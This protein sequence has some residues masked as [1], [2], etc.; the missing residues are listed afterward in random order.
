M[1][2]FS[3]LFLLTVHFQFSS[4]TV[5]FLT[6]ILSVTISLEQFLLFTCYLTFRAQ[7]Q[8]VYV[9]ILV[10]LTLRGSSC[11]RSAYLS[12]F[13]VLLPL[14][15]SLSFSSHLVQL[16]S[17]IRTPFSLSPHVCFFGRTQHFSFLHSFLLLHVLLLDSRAL[18]RD[19][20]CYYVTPL[21]SQLISWIQLI[22]RLSCLLFRSFISSLSFFLL[23]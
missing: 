4:H 6:A 15:L 23:G 14:L 7:S 12:Y 19:I 1:S 11:L 21:S 8:R 18:L 16:H 5:A 10:N 20:I 13:T 22:L 3:V 2:H 9:H 17:L